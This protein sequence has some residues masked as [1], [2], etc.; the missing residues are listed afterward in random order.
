MGHLSQTLIMNHAGIGNL[1]RGQRSYGLRVVYSDL[2]CCP[3]FTTWL[4]VTEPLSLCFTEAQIVFSSCSHASWWHHVVW[5]VD[6]ASLAPAQCL[7]QDQGT[8]RIALYTCLVTWSQL[9]QLRWSG[10]CL[11]N[12]SSW[13]WAAA[14]R[15]SCMMQ[16]GTRSGLKS[17]QNFISS[18][19]KLWCFLWVVFC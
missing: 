16:L 14:R 19:K 11:N 4:I 17:F 18:V 9:C 6:H 15:E 7:L 12:I 8:Q 3:Y 2:M 10:P 1:K 13:V 5:V